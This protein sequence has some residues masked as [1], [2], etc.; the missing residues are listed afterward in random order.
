MSEAASP[1]DRLLQNRAELARREQARDLGASLVLQ[2]Y[3][4]VKTAQI[5]ALEN[6]AV[7]QQ[8]EQTAESI[9]LFSARAD[10]SLSL[11]FAKSTVF[12][13]GQLLKGSRSVYQAALELGAMLAKLHLSEIVWKP[14]ADA[15]D[16]RAFVVALLAALRDP[17]ARE[18]L[19]HPTPRVRLRHVDASLLGD[20]EGEVSPEE[21]VLRTYAS[22]I[23]VMRRVFEDVAAERYALPHQAKRIAQKLVAL[24]EGDTPAFLGVTAMRNANHD[25]AGRAVNTSILAVAMA[26]QLTDDLGVLARVAMAALLHDVGRALVVAPPTGAPP[27]LASGVAPPLTREEES[28]LPA[29][30]ALV[31]TAMGKLHEASRVRAVITYEAQWLRRAG[32]LGPLYGDGARPPTVAARIVAAAHR[33]NELLTPDPGAE[34]FATPDEAIALMTREAPNAVELAVVALLVGAVGMFPTGTIVELTT[35]ERGVVTATSSHPAHYAEPTVRLLY[36]PDGRPYAT[37]LEV[38]LA[39]DA[40]R[41][42]AEVVTTHDPLLQRAADLATSRFLIAQSP[43]AADEPTVST[44]RPQRLARF[45]APLAVE[46]APAPERPSAPTLRDSDTTRSVVPPGLTPSA[47]G[48]LARTPV[49][50]LLVY[51]L[52]KALTGTL[53]LDDAG[54]EHAIVLERGVPARLWSSAQAQGPAS[55][56]GGARSHDFAGRLAR[57]ASLPKASGFAFHASADLI[58]GRAGATSGK[59]EPLAVV[60]AAFRAEPERERLDAVLE[61][62]TGHTLRLAPEVDVAAFGFEPDERA[63]VELLSAQGV[64]L[65]VLLAAEAAPPD[66]VRTVLATLIATRSFGLGGAAPVLVAA[67]GSLLPPQP[68]SAARPS[69]AMFTPAAPAAAPVAPLSSPTEPTSVSNSPAPLVL[70]TAAPSSPAAASINDVELDHID[71]T[72]PP[73]TRRP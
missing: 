6:T 12:V 21:Q 63:V 17:S 9:R 67:R 39:E 56:L 42:V 23:V 65:P 46:S 51:C 58:E 31:L 22:A 72:P 27:P 13:S 32:A 54:A 24:S 38:D 69:F 70:P 43:E 10:S 26:R 15:A 7:V 60:L 5:H 1:R 49:A 45:A 59:V 68:A 73:T 40:V 55:A 33:F 34:R 66:V 52:D 8:I 25:D 62:V 47:R 71:D 41:A 36:D 29:C 48:T 37:P 11:L 4:L 61:R 28:R 14:D 18:A 30:T 19:L 64:T 35:G 53:V 16:V 44:E 20:D 2:I 57:L 50:H 3:R